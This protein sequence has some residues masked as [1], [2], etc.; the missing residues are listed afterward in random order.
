MSS[1]PS[2]ILILGSGVFGLSTAYSL[3]QDPLFKDT[4][5][6]LIDRS[7]FPAPD[8]SSIDTSRI[9]RADYADIAYSRLGFEAQERWRHEW[10]GDGVY[11]ETGLALVTNAEGHDGTSSGDSAAGE[12]YMQRSMD[13]VRKLGLN[14]GTKDTGGDVQ[15]LKDKEEIQKIFQQPDQ[16]PNAGSTGDFGYVNWRSGWADAEGGMRILY[17]KVKETGRVNFVIGQVKHLMYSQSNQPSVD[18]AV[19]ATGEQLTADLTIVATGAW[20][21]SLIDLRGIA[22]AT[23]QIL[24]YLPITDAEQAVLERNPTIINESTGHFIIPPKDNL[25]KLALHGYGYANLIDIPHPE[26]PCSTTEMIKVSLPQTSHDEPNPPIPASAIQ[27]CRSFLAQTIPSLA[28]REFSHARLCWYTDTLSGDWL[29]DFHPK[30]SGLFVATGGS[31][32]A[33]KFLP[34]VGDKIVQCIKGS[35]PEGFKE[36]WKWPR[37]RAVE[38]QV[39]T[40]D[41]RGGTKGMYLA[42]ELAKGRAH[43]CGTFTFTP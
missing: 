37:E 42:E 16:N 41:W 24:C 5:I 12:S 21:P 10:W 27:T 18:G 9:I 13:N 19:L 28:D 43:S 35:P 32:H 29:I 15:P 26:Q 36:K 1:T 40:N 33:Y 4:K 38:D 3:T 22:S 25:L 14:I 7:T 34:V 20:T 11:H 17:Q 39:F 2:S 31:G 6:T 8:G 30:Y 23:G